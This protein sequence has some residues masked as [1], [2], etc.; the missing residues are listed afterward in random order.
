MRS[1]GPRIAAAEAQKQQAGIDHAAAAVSLAGS[2]RAKYAELLHLTRQRGVSERIAATYHRAAEAAEARSKVG[3]VPKPEV[4]RA[5]LAEADAKRQVRRLES[6]WRKSARELHTLMGGT[7]EPAWTLP[8]EAQGPAAE[9]ASLPA[10]ADLEAMG[11]AHR[12]DLERAEFDTQLA[13]AQLRLA[14]TGLFPTLNAGIDV[15]TDGSGNRTVG[16]FFSLALPIFNTGR[17]AMTLAEDQY[18]LADKSYVALRTQVRADVRSAAAMVRIAQDD[19]TFA[20]EQMLPQ[21]EQNVKLA[22]EAFQLG[23]ADL[24]SYLNT[25]RDYSVALQAA[26]D[27]RDGLN[28]AVLGLEQALGV[29]ASRITAEGLAQA[30]EAARAAEERPTP[31]ADSPTWT[32]SIGSQVSPNEEAQ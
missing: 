9:L 29:A 25:L 6:Q 23:A 15:S 24:D 28:S 10:D 4:N 30:A 7:G 32:S 16:P 14:R 1:R 2:V 11:L 5:R 12:L 3:L 21:Q 26:E 17:V 22:L 13:D 19:V 31:P 27:A 18:R 20:V 8:G